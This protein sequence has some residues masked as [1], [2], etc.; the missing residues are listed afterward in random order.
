MNQTVVR[1][2]T[3]FE[4]NIIY[5]NILKVLENER[6]L[7]IIHDRWEESSV[8]TALSQSQPDLLISGIQL[9]MHF[10]MSIYKELKQIYPNMKIIHL[11]DYI[12]KRIIQQ[13]IKSGADG[14]LLTSDIC[15]ELMPAIETVLNGEIY[16]VPD[17]SVASE[18]DFSKD[19]HSELIDID[20]HN[21]V[22][23]VH[24]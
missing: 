7:Y 13:F 24:T 10:G 19:I 6:N 21:S 2:L 11:S 14:F 5:Q 8:F 23:T 16:A 17:A 18:V 15:D 1:I 20:R 22:F 12:N 3:I 4:R 9:P